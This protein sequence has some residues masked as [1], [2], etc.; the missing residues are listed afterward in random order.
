[1][2]ISNGIN[3]ILY[4]INKII[5]LKEYNLSDRD[6][7][8][9]NMKLNCF[10]FYYIDLLYNDIIVLHDFSNNE[11]AVYKVQKFCAQVI[12]PLPVCQNNEFIILKP[13]IIVPRYINT[14]KDIWIIFHELC[15]LLSIGKYIQSDE[16]VNILNHSF[17]LNQ[18]SYLLNNKVACVNKIEFPKLNELLNDA[19]TWHLMECIYGNKIVPPDEYILKNAAKIKDRSDIKE[20]IN[21]YF[22]GKV[23]IL[24][25]RLNLTL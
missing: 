2:L 18:Y 17:G 14:I 23:N 7:D 24:Q 11:K 16:N 25:R 13:A 5:T 9:L 3:D 1:M 15:H 19:I 4:S 6:V 21:L 22:T 10:D 8:W 12:D 20:I